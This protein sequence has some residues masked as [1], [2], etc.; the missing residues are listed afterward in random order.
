MDA[1]LF[2]SNI[3]NLQSGFTSLLSGG[4]VQLFT[5]ERARSRGAEIGLSWVPLPGWNPGLAL[6]FNGAWIDAIYQEF[7]NGP[8]Y[9]EITGLYRND[10]DHS[11]NRITHTPEWSGTIGLTQI[12]MLGRG[13]LELGIDDNYNSKTFSAAQNAQEQEAYAVLNA[14]IGYVYTPWKLRFTVAGQNLLERRYHYP[15]GPTDFGTMKTLA[16]PREFGVRLGWEF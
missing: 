12:V 1:A 16:A 5:V 6:S 10:F 14:R 9:G 11:G 7:P 13:A 15:V 4:V 8:G 2:H 3:D